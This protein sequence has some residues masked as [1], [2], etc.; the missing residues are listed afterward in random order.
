MCLQY[1]TETKT[2]IIVFNTCSD[3]SRVGDKVGV[4]EVGGIEPLHDP[5]ACHTSFSKLSEG[6]EDV[7]QRELR[8][9]YTIPCD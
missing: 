5:T 8:H 4:D 1:A 2:K 3:G 7:I 9:S 6:S